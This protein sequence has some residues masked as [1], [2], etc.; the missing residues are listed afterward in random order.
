MLDVLVGSMPSSSFFLSA[1][2]HG[3]R[4][5]ISVSSLKTPS[6]PFLVVT[7]NRRKLRDDT[8]V[9]CC[10]TPV[11]LKAHKARIG[12]ISDGEES[13]DLLLGKESRHPGSDKKGLVASFPLLLISGTTSTVFV[14]AASSTLLPYCL[15]NDG[16][17]SSIV[18]HYRVNVIERLVLS[19]P[20][21]KS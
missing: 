19:G 15:E 5:L 6:V 10:D 11:L 20:L 3:V 2:T 14:E 4:T 1:S 7:C 17:P 18:G 21:G 9:F 8:I 16:S 12:R 13:I